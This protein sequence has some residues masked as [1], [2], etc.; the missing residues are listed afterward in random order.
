MGQDRGCVVVA[1]DG[2]CFGW[3]ARL[4]VKVS[5]ISDLPNRAA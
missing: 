4:D 3:L 1:F 5:W 2:G